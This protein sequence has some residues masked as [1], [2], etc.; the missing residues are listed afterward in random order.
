MSDRT[1]HH[2]PAKDFFF[3][4]VIKPQS[5]H[6]V[7]FSSSLF[8]SPLFKVIP[9]P[10]I[11]L[12]TVPILYFFFFS[13]FSPLSSLS[14]LPISIPPSSLLSLSTCA[15][16][17]YTYVLSEQDPPSLLSLSPL[18][19]FKSSVIQDGRNKDLHLVTTSL[20]G[21]I[22]PLSFFPLFGLTS[23]ID[24]P[25]NATWDTATTTGRGRHPVDP[26][27]V[28]RLGWFGL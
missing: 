5:P 2:H 24:H 3:F 14:F 4:E 10:P 22:N 19:D 27:L 17:I 11:H 12:I 23:C 21:H 20:C 18:W 6:K 28:S 16:D 1:A 26:C 8:S 13:F 9:T 7:L 25:V 15:Y